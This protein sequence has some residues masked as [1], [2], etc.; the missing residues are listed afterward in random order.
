MSL[1]EGPEPSPSGTLKRGTDSL[2]GGAAA[3]VRTAG[4]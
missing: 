3:T 4:L 2:S 1:Y